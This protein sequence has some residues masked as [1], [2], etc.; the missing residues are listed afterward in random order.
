MR[1]SQDSHARLT[2]ERYAVNGGAPA[3]PTVDDHKH[4]HHWRYIW[5]PLVAAFIWLA[6]LLA[7]LITWLAQGHPFYVSMSPGQ[8]VVYISDVGAD[9]LKP[10][11]I[12]GCCVTAVG[13]FLTLCVAR[14]LRHS[15]RLH[16]NLRRRER[17]A[18]TIAIF[19]SFMGGA[20]LILLSVFDTK[21][22]MKTHRVFLF[23]FVF[24]VTISAI[25]TVLEFRWIEKAY[26]QAVHLRRAYIIKAV[27]AVVLIAAAIAFGVTLGRK[28]NVAAI[29]EWAIA[30]GFTFYLLT[31]WADLRASRNISAGELTRDKLI[32]AGQVAPNRIPTTAV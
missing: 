23:F 15:G 1:Q 30:F 9:M 32:A 18:S 14:W 7:M 24:G 11:F 5:I 25:F 29:I 17:V 28:Q 26:P 22:H 10:L 19:G 3:D 21:H 27:L 6:M 13:F 16:A 31:F 20:A 12:A 4:R 2:K 8:K